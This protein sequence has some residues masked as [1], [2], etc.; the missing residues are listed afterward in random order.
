MRILSLRSKI[1]SQIGTL[2]QI[3]S[4]NEKTKPQNDQG[5]P[6]RIS[7]LLKKMEDDKEKTQATLKSLRVNYDDKDLWLSPN[8]LEDENGKWVRAQQIKAP[9]NAEKTCGE[10]DYREG[11]EEVLNILSLC[12]FIDKL[13]KGENNLPPFTKEP[14][15]KPL[16]KPLIERIEEKKEDNDQPKNLRIKFKNKSGLE[17]EFYY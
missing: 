17:H 13:N 1:K 9:I 14:S 15:I 10:C 2:D 12:G 5:N 16:K 4:I 7:D 8:P 3:S 11:L 6:L